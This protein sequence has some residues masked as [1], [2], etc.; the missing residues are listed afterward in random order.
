MT[1]LERHLKKRFL[2]V[3]SAPAGTGKTTLANMLVEEFSDSITQSIS[4]TT[5]APRAGEINGKDYYFLSKEAFKA[6]ID[7]SEFLEYATVFGNEYGTLKK[8]VL[9]E[10]RRD[11]HVVLV[12]DTQGALALK[13]K[14]EALFIFIAPPSTEVLNE[15]LLK[16]KSESVAMRQKR[17]SFARHEM[18]QIKHYDYLIINDQLEHAYLV[19][20]SIILAEEHRIDHV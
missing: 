19:L 11:H 12:I 6:H 9:E 13:G 4:C 8:N 14:V 7:R 16:R 2:I 20:K 3:I 17:L 1:S 10:Q 18:E 5:R 15:R